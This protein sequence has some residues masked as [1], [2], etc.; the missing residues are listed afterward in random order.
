MITQCYIEIGPTGTSFFSR[1]APDGDKKQ[2]QRRRAV[3]GVRRKPAGSSGRKILPTRR[4]SAVFFCLPTRQAPLQIRRAAAARRGYVDNMHGQLLQ[5]R[6]ARRARMPPRCRPVERH[7]A[8]KSGLSGEYESAPG[9]SLA[10]WRTTG[11]LRRILPHVYP[12]RRDTS[13][14]AYTFLSHHLSTRAFSL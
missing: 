7:A 1:H 13:A 2:T 9:S 12:P 4:A 5:A 8:E 3:V 14:V 6:A 10:V 11:A